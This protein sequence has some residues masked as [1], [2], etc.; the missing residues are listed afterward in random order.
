MSLLKLSSSGIVGTGLK[1]RNGPHLGEGTPR[2][3]MVVGWEGA[4]GQQDIWE[5]ALAPREPHTSLICV[6]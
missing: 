2:L 5:E 3:S 4:R 1:L 6:D